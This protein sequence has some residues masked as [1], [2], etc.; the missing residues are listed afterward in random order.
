MALPLLPAQ[1][2]NPWYTE[3]NNWDTV[4]GADVTVA[5]DGVL[6]LEDL[7][8]T[9]T[10]RF[11][12]TTQSFMGRP[13]VVN[14]PEFV[15]GTAQWNNA[16][17]GTL[18]TVAAV[19][20]GG[21]NAVLFSGA[22]L[23]ASNWT[24]AAGAS[25][26]RVEAIY[27]S[28]EATG[29]LTT[30]VYI[31]RRTT[32]GAT[33]VLTT[34]RLPATGGEWRTFQIEAEMPSGTDA[35][36]AYV[37]GS[38]GLNYIISSV[39]LRPAV[40]VASRLGGI[41]PTINAV[42]SSPRQWAVVPTP[43]ITLAQMQTSGLDT[44]YWPWV[45]STEGITGAL[46]SYYLYWSTDHSTGAGGIAMAYANSPLGPW[47]VQGVV[48]TYAAPGSHSTET[49]SVLVRGANDLIMYFH[50]REYGAGNVQTQQVTA[51][52]T[53][54]D[55]I[56]WTRQGYALPYPDTMPGD[57]HSGYARPFEIGVDGYAMYSLAG[58][59]AFPRQAVWYSK[60]GV[61]WTLDRR[62]FS[63]QVDVS[64][65]MLSAVDMRLSVFRW[66][67]D[68]WAGVV[69][70]GASFV[71]RLRDDLR[72]FKGRMY[73]TN[74]IPETVVN[75]GDGKLYGYRQVPEGVIVAILEA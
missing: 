7:G 72:G 23:M 14:D 74:F 62:T 73:A 4:V 19:G 46:G 65:S 49:P 64:G 25:R 71:G 66:H 36:R 43:T 47:T 1:G 29:T 31:Q 56:N 8:P 61:I 35:V 16:G 10:G 57:G 27:K 48:F 51:Y 9:D 11:F 40:S 39:N 15:S 33:T 6:K 68:L 20:T 69:V 28:V 75:G 42:Q 50:N 12:E 45:I 2:Q 53:S 24:P 34:A 5:K 13:N 54:T 17:S 44:I 30:G 26:W 59:T 52:A 38:A 41:S 63:N 58:G 22:R 60:D 21:S 37:S 67:D 18:P 32:A 70:Q 55:G 3:R